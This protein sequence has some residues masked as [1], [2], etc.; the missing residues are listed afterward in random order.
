M[1]QSDTFKSSDIIGDNIDMTRSPSQMSVDR[2]RKSWHWFLLVGLQKRVINQDLDDSTPIAD[3][4]HVEN[5]LFVPNLKDCNFPDRNY[6]H[7]IMHVL[8]KYIRCFKKYDKCLPKHLPHPHTDEL[9]KQLDYVLLDLLD[10]GEDMISILEHIHDKFIPRTDDDDPVVIKRK[11]F[12]GDVLTNSAQL[13]KLNH[14]TDYDKL[15][16]VIHRPEGLHRMM[17]LLL[18]LFRKFIN[19]F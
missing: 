1:N 16:G 18:V 13:A 19:L 7:H 10:K 2:K 17:N 3:I 8:I 9:S 14:A 12:G 6:I 11:V 4:N 5:S 15:T